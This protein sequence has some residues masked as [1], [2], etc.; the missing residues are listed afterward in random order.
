MKRSYRP[1]AQSDLKFN[2]KP[3]GRHQQTS[4]IVVGLLAARLC[5]PEYFGAEAQCQ[6]YHTLT[7]VSVLG[8]TLVHNERSWK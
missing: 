1:A 2:L 7:S 3:Y 5:S 6:R 8:C 4:A